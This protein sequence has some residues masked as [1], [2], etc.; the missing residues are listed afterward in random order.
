MNQL[1]AVSGMRRRRDQG[2]AVVEVSLLAPWIL[3]LFVGAVDVGFYSY[4]L[5]CTQNAA[6]VA[7]TYTSSNSS[8]AGDSVGACQ[9][10]L[11]EMSTMA[12]VRSL[13]SCGSYPLIVTATSE[14][15]VDGSA[16]STVS[17][18]YRTDQMIPIP[19]LLSGRLTVTRKAQM[20]VP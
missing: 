6:R 9:S 3:F 8:L 4:A 20:R 19:G 12:N 5:I 15:G 1:T 11:A 10:A 16:A 18:T 17:V 14:P 2:H 7:A 13:T